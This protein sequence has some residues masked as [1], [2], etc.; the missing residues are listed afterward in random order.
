MIK[1]KTFINFIMVTLMVSFLTISVGKVSPVFAQAALPLADPVYDTEIIALY[2][3]VTQNVDAPQLDIFFFVSGALAAAQLGAQ[4]AKL[5]S[6]YDSEENIQQ[7]LINCGIQLYNSVIGLIPSGE[8][9]VGVDYPTLG[10]PR[11]KLKLLVATLMGNAVLARNYSNLDDFLDDNPDHIMINFNRDLQLGV[12]AVFGLNGGFY[13]WQKM[14]SSIG[15]VQNQ[16]WITTGVSE[17]T[18]ANIIASVGIEGIRFN[19]PDPAPLG[20]FAAIFGKTGSYD[21]RHYQNIFIDSFN[22]VVSLRDDS[23]NLYRFNGNINPVGFRFGNS[24]YYN[25]TGYGL[26]ILYTD[27]QVTY[28]SSLT[29][30]KGILE[31]YFQVINSLTTFPLYEDFVRHIYVG[32]DWVGREEVDIE[33]DLNLEFNNI[34]YYQQVTNDYML[35]IRGLMGD[36][37]NYV[38]LRNPIFDNLYDLLGNLVVPSTINVSVDLEPITQLLAPPIPVNL[39]D[40]AE[41]TDNTYL[42]RVKEH[43]KNFGDIFVQYFAFWHN[44]DA[45]IIYSLFG[46]TILVLVG[47][48]IGKWGHS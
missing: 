8:Y 30:V 31:Y 16:T 29:S 33:S 44:V 38:Y 22:H 18:I 13:D 10:I 42:E 5:I 27:L 12:N 17:T 24:V 41:L 1:N 4:D 11:D 6:P 26:T 34:P 37:V 40:I 7:W 43:A 36:L 21:L 47:A 45:D 25:V 48:F 32:V 39:N 9:Y 20:D 35:D 23:G 28:P 14:N 15:E 2:D 46:A 19:H 3:Y